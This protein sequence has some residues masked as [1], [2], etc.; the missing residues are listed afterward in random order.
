MII[1]IVHLHACRSERE[2]GVLTTKVRSLQRQLADGNERPLE[3]KSVEGHSVGELEK[4]ITSMKKVIEKLQSENESLKRSTTVSRLAQ[5]KAS[6]GMKKV[7]SLQ[8]EN[9]KLK[10]SAER[11]KIVFITLFLCLD[12]NATTSATCQL[13]FH[14]ASHGLCSL[15]KISI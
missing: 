7:T 5:S 3:A 11:F 12:G 13:N 8:E 15:G 9:K 4:V 14:Q 6:E 1:C 2:R 10:A